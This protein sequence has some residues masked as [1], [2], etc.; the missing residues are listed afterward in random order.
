M[1]DLILLDLMLPDMTGYELFPKLKT[2]SGFDEIPV[3]ILTGK[4]A[5]TDK[6][7]GMLL[8]TNEYVTKPF[9]PEK[10]VGLIKRYM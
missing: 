5:P 9:N 7:K 3:F 6:M 2:I 10:L 4:R 8:G 1:P